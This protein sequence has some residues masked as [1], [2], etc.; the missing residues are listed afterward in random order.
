MIGWIV[1]WALLAPIGVLDRCGDSGSAVHPRRRD[2]ARAHPYRRRPRRR[3]GPPGPDGA[4]PHGL[5][6]AG[7]LTDQSAFDDFQALLEELYPGARPHDPR[8]PRAQRPAVPLAGQKS[9]APTVLMAH[10]DVVPADARGLDQTAPSAARWKTACSGA[11]APWTPKGS[12][13]GIFEGAE[14]RLKA[15]FT[16]ARPLYLPGRG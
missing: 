5:L 2:P 1:L 16:P 15:G 6:Q 4:H 13:C 9:G 11:G 10:Y 14:A 3:H 7:G 12:L 8:K